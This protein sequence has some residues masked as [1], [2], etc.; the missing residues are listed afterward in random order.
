M[1]GRCGGL[2]TAG[3]LLRDSGK[4]VK[5]RQGRKEDKSVEHVNIHRCMHG[6]MVGMAGLGM[7]MHYLMPA[8]V[9]CMR[10]ICQ[11]QPL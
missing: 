8:N 7:Q 10:R 2:T 3:A 11:Q 9:C 6:V 1:V 5:S 4:P